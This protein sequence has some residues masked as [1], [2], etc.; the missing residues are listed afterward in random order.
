MRQNIFHLFSKA[1][2]SRINSCYT[3]FKSETKKKP[4]T[5]LL[6]E[7]LAV[8]C[9]PCIMRHPVFDLSFTDQNS[10]SLQSFISLALSLMLSQGISWLCVPVIL[11]NNSD[12]F[13]SI[14]SMI[15][16]LRNFL[17]LENMLW[18]MHTLNAE[19]LNGS[20]IIDNGGTTFIVLV[21][22]SSNTFCNSIFWVATV[23]IPLDILIACGNTIF[24]NASTWQVL[25]IPS[26]S[27]LD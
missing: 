9:V 22:F 15:P 3:I 5:S 27:S 13:Q 17:Q 11:S 10:F 1:L 26:L 12:L 20:S 2:W 4:T 7:L 16:I 21:G 25:L 6:V 14:S 24:V 23:Q 8:T 18:E 19:H